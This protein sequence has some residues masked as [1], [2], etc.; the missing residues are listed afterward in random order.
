MKFLLENYKRLIFIVILLVLVILIGV[1]SS[2]YDISDAEN[3][4]GNVFTSV[5]KVFFDIGET[6]SNA[7]YS[8]R[9]VSKLNERN[10]YLE[11]SVIELKDENRKLKEIVNSS[12][13]LK[14][15][16]EL[17]NRLD[18]DFEKCQIVSLDGS[19]W[20]N[21]FTINKGTN[22][23]LKKNDIVIKA[24]TNEDSII[25]V[26]LLGVV[27]EVGT[28]WAKVITIIDEECKVTFKDIEN[29][30]AGIIGGSIDQTISGYFLNNKAEA[31]VGDEI[32][33]SGI[34]NIYI[35]NINIGK[36][37]KIENTTDAS[38]MK[39]FIEPT[40]DFSNIYDV[41]VLKVER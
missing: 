25:N 12:E 31:E 7:I 38:T 21:R 5:Q 24:V 19:T 22:S 28:N 20:F 27:T 13:I 41:Y 30:E 33:T 29:G 11:T 3:G 39:I 9:N 34:G 26:G 16:Y 8:I 35:K 36:I 37:S 2:T 14:A 15:E 4:T 17:Q 32:F 10:E 40:V 1:S 23:G 18:Y 6:F